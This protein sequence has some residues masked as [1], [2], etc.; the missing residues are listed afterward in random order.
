[1]LCGG[2]NFFF[3]KL[4]P[5]LDPNSGSN[6]SLKPKKLLNFFQKIILRLSRN[7]SI[8]YTQPGNVIAEGVSHKIFNNFVNFFAISVKFLRNIA[9][10]I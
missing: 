2:A 1:M 4:G 3:M 8:L 7:G 9:N 5:N 6:P 10:W